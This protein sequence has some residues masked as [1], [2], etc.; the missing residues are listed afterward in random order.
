MQVPIEIIE[1]AG[2]AEHLK[3]FEGA[4][5]KPIKAGM[6]GIVSS[7]GGSTNLCRALDTLTIHQR[8]EQHK[9]VIIITDGGVDDRGGVTSYFKH[10]SELNPIM[11]GINTDE[12]GSAKAFFPGRGED[13]ADAC[14]LPAVFTRILKDILGI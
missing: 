6:G 1:F 2:N 3:R 9:H 13:I 12:Y 7:I 4:Y 14:E 10:H 5:D 8:K 11:I